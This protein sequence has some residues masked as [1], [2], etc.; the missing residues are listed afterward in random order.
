[1]SG[2]VGALDGFL[3]MIRTPRRR[4]AANS[5]LYFSGHYSRMG[6][7]DQAMCDTNCKIT[8]VAVLAPGRSSDLAKM[9]WESSANAFC[10][11]R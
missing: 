6:L 8:Y 1:M 3:F 7:N 9:D 2:C 10:E 5:W 4:E 11:C